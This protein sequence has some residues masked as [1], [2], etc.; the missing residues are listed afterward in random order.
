[1]ATP[2][3]MAAAATGAFVAFTP[4]SVHEPF[5]TEKLAVPGLVSLLTKTIRVALDTLA[6]TVPAGKVDRSNWTSPASAAAPPTLILTV[7]PKF[8]AFPGITISPVRAQLQGHN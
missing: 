6:A 1:M 3:A 8:D 2:L 5:A 4:S 7:E